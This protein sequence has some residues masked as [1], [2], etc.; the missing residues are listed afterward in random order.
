MCKTKFNLVPRVLSPEQQIRVQEVLEE[1]QGSSLSTLGSLRLACIAS[2]YSW[3]YPVRLSPQWR[4]PVKKE[5]EDLIQLGVIEISD[6]SWSSHV[7]QVKKKDGGLRICIDFRNAP[8]TFQQM[9]V[10][11]LRGQESWSSQELEYLGCV[12]GHG[13]VCVPDARVETTASV[14]KPNTIKELRS[15]LCLVG[16]YRKFI[17]NFATYTKHLTSATTKCTPRNVV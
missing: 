3:R 10:G 2:R 16:Y 17:A 12:I 15:L 1:F 6:S 11:I 14:V 4:D 8:V 13:V 5:I 7:V 9:M